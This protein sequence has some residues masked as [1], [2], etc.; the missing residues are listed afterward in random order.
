MHGSRHI[1]ITGNQFV[2]NDL[3]SI[4]LMPGTASYAARPASAGQPVQ[5]DNSDG[6][7]IIANNIT[8]DFGHGHSHWV[9]GDD[10]VPLRFG[11]GPEPDSPPLS[12]VIIQG[13][14]IHDA[15]PDQ[16]IPNANSK[17]GPRYKYAV[18]VEGGDKGPKG[19]HFSNNI[20]HAGKQGIS[21]VELTP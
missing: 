6:G 8:S 1:L 19:L 5:A 4:G 20:L 17:A 18:L 16:A 9:W 10:G 3:W 21:N 14:I 2:R 12:D 7:S 11:R 15:G 13:N